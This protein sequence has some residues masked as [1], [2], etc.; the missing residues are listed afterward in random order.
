MEIFTNFALVWSIICRSCFHWGEGF[1]Q[2]CLGMPALPPF[3][4][5]FKQLW[6]FL[7]R[8]IEP[9]TY[10]PQEQ[11]SPAINLLSSTCA[12]FFS[13]V[14]GKAYRYRNS[15]VNRH[16]VCVHVV[17]S[18]ELLQLKL[19]LCRFWICDLLT[20]E[21]YTALLPMPFAIIFSRGQKGKSS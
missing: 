5:L 16:G 2:L 17:I 4:F 18:Y 19:V 1:L 6:I 13:A 20:N 8:N 10:S 7:S 9:P 21:V 14:T 11:R 3:V 15:N 12:V